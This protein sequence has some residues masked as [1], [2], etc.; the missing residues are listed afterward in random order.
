MAKSTLKHYLLQESF[1]GLEEGLWSWA[2]GTQA[3]DFDGSVFEGGYR[4]VM[5]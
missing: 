2:T 5:K 1:A 4:Q 3:K